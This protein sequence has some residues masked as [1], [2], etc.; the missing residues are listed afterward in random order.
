MKYL[1]TEY[2]NS[3]TIH[4]YDICAITVTPAG[5]YGYFD[6]FYNRMYYDEQNKFG[7]YGDDLLTRKGPNLPIL[8]ELSEEE[9]FQESTLYD[10]YTLRDAQNEIMKHI[11][12]TFQYS[13]Q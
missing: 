9:F 6:I 10:A 3:L 8:N 11:N 12:G 2:Q 5:V 7:L 13:T 1:H 4:V